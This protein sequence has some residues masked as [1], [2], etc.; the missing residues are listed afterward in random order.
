MPRSP[1]DA[2]GIEKKQCPPTGIKKKNKPPFPPAH[3][4]KKKE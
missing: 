4:I 1:L 3:G 2:P